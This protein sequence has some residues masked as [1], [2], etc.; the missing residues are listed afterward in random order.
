TR[1]AAPYVA[2]EWLAQ[3]FFWLGFRT[4][5]I[6]GLIL[7]KPLALFVTALLVR[8][9]SRRLN[10][11]PIASLWGAVLAILSMTSHL[12]VRPHLF[13]FM[14]LAGASLLLI[15]VREG[16]RR[17]TGMLGALQLLWANLHGGFILGIALALSG[18]SL[19][20]AGIGA[21]VSLINPNGR[22]LYRFVL[23]FAD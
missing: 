22:D 16:S 5:G 15:G 4:A 6:N 9:T 12:F 21:T 17:A 18:L 1:A 23:I 8:R 3:V 2:H 11:G 10:A 19:A 13:T 20:A 7:F 14:M